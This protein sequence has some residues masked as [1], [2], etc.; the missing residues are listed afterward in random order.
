M[1][2]PSRYIVRLFQ[3]VRASLHFPS[4][5]SVLARGPSQSKRARIATAMA[6]LSPVSISDEAD[7][8]LTVLNIHTA[9]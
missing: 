4:V 3:D 6:V 1:S 8:T 9:H 2:E 7:S 5:G